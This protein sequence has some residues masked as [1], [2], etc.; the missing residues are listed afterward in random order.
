VLRSASDRFEAE[1]LPHLND[2]FRTANRVLGDKNRAEDIAQEVY[3]Q[4][5]KSFERFQPGTNCR[6]WTARFSRL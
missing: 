3:L 1:A 6:A 5:W 2:F 4:A